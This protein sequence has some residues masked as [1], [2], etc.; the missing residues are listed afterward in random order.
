MS[1]IRT[2]TLLISYLYTEAGVP[3]SPDTAGASTSL[4]IWSKSNFLKYIMKY[5]NYYRGGWLCSSVLT[6]ESQ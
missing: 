2:A 6:I 4:G 1:S 5:L 3:V